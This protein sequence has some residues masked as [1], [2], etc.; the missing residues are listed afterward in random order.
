MLVIHVIIPSLKQ[1]H[2]RLDYS[3]VQRYRLNFLKESNEEIERRKRD[4]QR[5][6][7]EF[8]TETELEVDIKDV[9]QPGSGII[10]SQ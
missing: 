8:I 7:L 3:K 4:A 2:F 6:K 1:M 5:N 9:Y 10:V